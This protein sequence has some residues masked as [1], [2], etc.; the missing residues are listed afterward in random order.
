MHDRIVKI[1]GGSERLDI[2]KRVKEKGFIMIM[3]VKKGWKVDFVRS[4]AQDQCTSALVLHIGTLKA[5]KQVVAILFKK[6]AI[7]MQ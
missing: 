7:V 6:S 2:C 4:A 5:K 1:I 3:C